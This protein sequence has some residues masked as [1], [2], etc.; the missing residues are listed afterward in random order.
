MA[1]GI[2]PLFV[3]TKSDELNHLNPAKRADY[4]E[5]RIRTYMDGFQSLNNCSI[6]GV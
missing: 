5:S 1:K 3:L 2:K 6:V 4:I